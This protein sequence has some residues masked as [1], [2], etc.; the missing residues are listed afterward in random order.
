MG[1]FVYWSSVSVFFRSTSFGSKK[2]FFGCWSDK[3]FGIEFEIG[4]E[5]GAFDSFSE[6][7]G[8]EL[9]EDQT[10]VKVR[11]LL[12]LSPRLATDMAMMLI[13]KSRAVN[14]Q[15]RP[16]SILVYR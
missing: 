16:T 1:Y 3:H 2:L 8:T 11:V 10:G 14:R 12:A 5:V 6:G 9:V 7:K 15:P 4:F 13:A